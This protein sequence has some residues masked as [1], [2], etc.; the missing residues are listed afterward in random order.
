MKIDELAALGDEQLVHKELELERSLLAH[1]FRH[2]LGQLENNSVL[3][4]T[5]RD[6]A[7]AQTLLTQREREAGL[8]KGALRARHGSSFVPSAASAPSASAGDDFLKGILDKQESA[9]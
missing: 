6:I 9:E 8:T 3:K 2:R 1:T 4:Q 5:R 7:R